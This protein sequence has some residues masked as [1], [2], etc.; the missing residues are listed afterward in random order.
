M[1]NEVKKTFELSHSI[2]DIIQKL[3]KG[4]KVYSRLIIE[5]LEKIHKVNVS[6]PYLDFLYEIVENYFEVEV[7][8]TS[9]ISNFLGTL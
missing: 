4:T 1:K 9:N 5:D 6:I 3:E 8:K 2:V 7:P